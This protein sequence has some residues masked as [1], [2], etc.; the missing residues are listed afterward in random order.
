M[1]QQKE[2]EARAGAAAN[3][4][5]AKTA[6]E[7]R[8]EILK[9]LDPFSGKRIAKGWAD[10]IKELREEKFSLDKNQRQDRS[11]ESDPAERDA[12]VSTGVTIRMRMNKDR[13]DPD[14]DLKTYKERRAEIDDAV[15]EIYELSEASDEFSKK[16]LTDAI[17]AMRAE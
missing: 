6:D 9:E 1:S 17:V 4:K 15:I 2:R 13:E 14:S 5:P 12:T 3:G 16:D 8:A 11:K 7:I 10:A